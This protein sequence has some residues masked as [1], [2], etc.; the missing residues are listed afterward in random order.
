MLRAYSCNTYDS[1][2]SFSVP[3]EGL[4]VWGGAAACQQVTDECIL[5]GGYN[6]IWLDHEDIKKIELKIKPIAWPMNTMK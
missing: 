4:K 2:V 3:S 6:Q 5:P 1:Y